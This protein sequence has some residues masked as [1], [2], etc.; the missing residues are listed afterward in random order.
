MTDPISDL[1]TR[2]RNAQTAGHKTVTVPASTKKMQIIQ[3]LLAEGYIESVQQDEDDKGKK[4]FRIVLRYDN[5]GVPA[6]RELKRV[7]KSGRRA[8]VKV[9]EIPFYRSGLGT[10]I[11]STSQGMMTGREAKR[12]NIGGELICSIF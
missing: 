12:Q 11:V 8:Y 7:S 1:L 9:D 3:V 5:C 6:I 10:V 4:S 2:I